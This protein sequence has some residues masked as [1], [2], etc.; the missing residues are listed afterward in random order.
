MAK[1]MGAICGDI[2]GSTYE[3]KNIKYCPTLNELISRDNF[4][5]D[6][7]VMT[8]AVAKALYDSFN[9][10]DRP[11]ELN[12]KEEKLICKHIEDELITFGRKYPDSG[13][14]ETFYDWIMFE[15]R[16]PYN[17]WGNG[18]AMRVSYAGWASKNLKEALFLAKCTAEVTHNHPYGIKGA[19]IV[20][21]CIYFLR[22]G[23]SK[24]F[25]RDFASKYYDMNFTLD[26]IRYLY[27]YDVS[28]QGSV[29]QAIMA[30]LEGN[31]FEEV[32]SLAISIGG[33]SD[34]IA[35]IA[36]SIA[37]VIYPIPENI[38]GI[39][40]NTLDDYLKETINIVVN[41]IET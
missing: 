28:C 39:A 7:T 29:P 31:S 34:T 18:S 12:E 13:Y 25:I 2:L 5:T 24:A 33:D 9:E 19:Q 41:G 16:K 37:E 8:C 30:F 17:S 23:A 14:G 4:F 3:W 27:E 21:A 15:I 38:L 22:Q 20:A 32:I 36:G 10:L 6:D 1:M 26:E 35:A 11:L 40:N